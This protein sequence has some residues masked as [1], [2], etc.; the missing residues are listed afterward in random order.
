MHEKEIAR[1]LLPIK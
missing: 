1:D